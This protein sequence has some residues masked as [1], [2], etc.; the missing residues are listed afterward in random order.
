MNICTW[1]PGECT[2]ALT[3]AGA[4]VLD[5]GHEEIA[6]EFWKKLAEG[7]TFAG[8]VEVLTTRFGGSLT[9]MPG[10]AV[11][12]HEGEGGRIA[13]RGDFTIEVR[14]EEETVRLD[15]GSLITWSERRVGRIQAWSVEAP[16]A[17]IA[18]VRQTHAFD[19][20]DAVLPVS[21]VEYGQVRPAPSGEESAD[22][23]S[24]G[25]RWG[26]GSP[27]AAATGHVAEPGSLTEGG[28]EPSP[29]VRTVPTVEPSSE[30][31]SADEQP[32]AAE[33]AAAEPS[34]EEAGPAG[35]AAQEAPATRFPLAALPAEVSD[36]MVLVRGE[37]AGDAVEPMRTRWNSLDRA[38]AE[39]GLAA[40]G[41][42]DTRVLEP[43]SLTYHG[44][45]VLAVMCLDD[46]PNPPFT[47]K[48]R[49]CGKG[50]SQSL[51]RI[52]R[53][54][55]GR[56]VLS[57]GETVLLDRD[58]VLGRN[59]TATAS[60][61]RRA[62]RLVA[63]DDV[64]QEVSRSHCE[65]RVDGWDARVRDLGSQNG[66][67]LLREGAEAEKV[68]EGSPVLLRPGD[69]FRLGATVTVRLES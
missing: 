20:R 47:Q 44:A 55:V 64:E 50:M 9:D 16:G 68:G 13:V 37:D 17:D 6:P 53:P 7:T 23:A 28:A 51:A 60:V 12:L 34:T 54:P 39:H 3:P 43:E 1:Y 56:L 42:S 31:R 63:I 11:V 45:E 41:V 62:P 27:A 61:G 40:E 30:D 35:E 25:S 59:P 2:V 66:T 58:V 21:L 15:G 65:I 29:E 46:H 69:V 10:F 52:T 48:C 18:K 57:T 33:P 26:E 22:D 4:V 19:A 67:Y 24:E 8:I 14:T 5:P 36:T 49:I 38:R 32:A